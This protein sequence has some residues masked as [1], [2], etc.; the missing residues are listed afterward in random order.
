MKIGV[1]KETHPNENR[2]SIIPSDVA[3]YVKLGLQV[4]V[5]QGIGNSIGYADEAYVK[6]GAEVSANRDELFAEGNIILA[7]RP[8]SV[9]DGQKLR[10]GT[11]L[12]GYLDPGNNADLLRTLADRG[13]TAVSMEYIPR[14]TR[15]QKMDALSSQA[16]L[17]GYAA[18]LLAA[19]ETDHVL[20]MMSTPAG[21]INASRVFV[22]GAGVAGLQ[23]I[24]TAKRLG[25]RVDAF[26]TRPVVAEQVRSLGA[27]FV[28]VD[29]GETGQNKDGYAN[30]LTEDQLAKQRE[31][32]AKQCAMSDVVITTAQIFGRKAPIIITKEMVAGMRP[33][34]MIVDLAVETGG[35]TEG[36]I[37]GQVVDINGVR[38]FGQVNM[39]G[40]VAYHAS[41]M[42]SANLYN[43]VDE[44]WDKEQ[45]TLKL[46]LEDD[47]LASCVKTHE[48]KIRG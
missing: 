4:I 21:T 17:A 35:N 45:K 2:C 10:P 36:A 47:I 19:A 44:Y 18:V 43:F 40:R 42:Y 33:G 5:E 34:S 32:M 15:A 20:P 8:L 30:A 22:I 11:L 1:I 23:A 14:S 37:A 24:A 9:S 27:R 28:E 25:A 6:A 13:V 39:P 12:V 7:L 26:D 3:R 48:G 16:S 38:I 41:Q 46:S 29:L 31:V